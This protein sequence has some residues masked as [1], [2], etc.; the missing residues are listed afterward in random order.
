[1]ISDAML[2]KIFG[3]FSVPAAAWT[4]VLM[5]AVAWFRTRPLIM[6][7]INERHRDTET[8]KAGDWSRLRDL[9]E[10]LGEDRDKS[11]EAEARCREE[12][13]DVRKRL[14]TLEG[15]QIGRG[16]A[17]QEVA[18]IEGAKRLTEEKE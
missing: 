6:A 7:R 5:V 15:Y 16:Q 8:A 17:A 3:L 18:I 14:A 11:R 13:V 10:Q 12:L 2:G 1:M 9:V 4:F